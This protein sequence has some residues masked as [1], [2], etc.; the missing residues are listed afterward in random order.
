MATHLCYMPTLALTNNMRFHSLANVDKT[1]PV[2]RVFGTIGWII[3]GH[4]HRRHRRGVQ[5]HHL[6]V[7]A[8]SS[9][10]LALYSLTLP[11]TPAPAKAAGEGA[12]SLLRGCLCAAQNPPLSSSPS[13]RC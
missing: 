7:A 8:I 12:R 2:V 3:A 1:F 13:A 10:L 6:P 4:F 9:V 5:R 11:H